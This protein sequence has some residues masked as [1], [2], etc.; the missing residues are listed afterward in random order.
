LR[1]QHTSGYLLIERSSSR[2]DELQI[3]IKTRAPGQQLENGISDDVFPQHDQGF[4]QNRSDHLT[5]DQVTLKIF[6]EL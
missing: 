2:T 6:H 5:D 1:S 4:K 3:V